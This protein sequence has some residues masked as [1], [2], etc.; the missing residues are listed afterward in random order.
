MKMVDDPDTDHLIAWGDYGN[1]FV[2]HNQAEFS[3]SL[4]PY[5]SVAA[6][7]LADFRLIVVEIL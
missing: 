2:I 4:L 7:T 1:T 3:Q 5:Y 6:I